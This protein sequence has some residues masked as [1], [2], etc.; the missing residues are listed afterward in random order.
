MTKNTVCSART[1][2][3]WTY[4]NRLRAAMVT[5][6]QTYLLQRR[7]ST[8]SNRRKSWLK[9]PI[10]RTGKR[11]RETAWRMMAMVDWQMQLQ[12]W[13]WRWAKVWTKRD[14]MRVLEGEMLFLGG[15]RQQVF[16]LRLAIL[17]DV[18]TECFGWAVMHWAVMHYF[19]RFRRK[20]DRCMHTWLI[21]SSFRACS[22]FL[23]CGRVKSYC[24]SS[25]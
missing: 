1:S 15:D 18:G 8:S 19:R 5:R 24:A 9:I 25:L 7:L 21:T 23:Q 3:C 6:G 13:I 14:K 12:V 17:W 11:Q 16:F 10:L 22:I 20:K 4:E 2:N